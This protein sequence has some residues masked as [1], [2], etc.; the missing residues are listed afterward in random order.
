MLVAGVGQGLH[1]RLW[2]NVVSVA[3]CPLAAQ[4]PCCSTRTEMAA[5]GSGE[6]RGHDQQGHLGLVTDRNGQQSMCPKGAK[7]T[8]T[9]TQLCHRHLRGLGHY[10]LPFVC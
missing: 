6:D 10:P 3:P 9:I 5:G 1:R 7:L 4:V 2:W 8:R